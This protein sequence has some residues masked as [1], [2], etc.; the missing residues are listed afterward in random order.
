MIFTLSYLSEESLRR[1]VKCIKP[2]KVRLKLSLKN[3]YNVYIHKNRETLQN[4]W[5]V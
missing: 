3:N 4:S 1:L 5:K 2:C